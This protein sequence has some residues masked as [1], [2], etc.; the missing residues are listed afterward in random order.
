MASSPDLQ[1]GFRVAHLANGGGHALRPGPYP[2]GLSRVRLYE[3]SDSGSSRTPSPHCLPDPSRLMMPTRPVVVRAASAVPRVPAFRLP[4]A[5]PPSCDWSAVESFHLHSIVQ[6][7]VAHWKKSQASRRQLESAGNARQK[8]PAFRG[9]GARRRDSRHVQA[10]RETR[11]FDLARPGMPAGPSLSQQSQS[12]RT[13][14]QR[15]QVPGGR[16]GAASDSTG[17][18]SSGAASSPRTPS[19]SGTT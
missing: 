7:L 15:R 13:G 11:L 5:S 8:V 6:R 17:G 1:T 10:W 9:A 19:A 2:S 12:A 3:A 4:S 16:R 18:Y 14:A